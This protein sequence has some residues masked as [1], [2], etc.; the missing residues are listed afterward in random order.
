MDYVLP[1]TILTIVVVANKCGC[2]P[3]P[4]PFEFPIQNS[5]SLNI[6]FED[7]EIDLEGMCE[8]K[9]KIICDFQNI[10]KQLECGIQPDLEFLLEEI[11]AVYEG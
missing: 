7:D 1:K 4:E 6:P 2:N 3:T 9:Q 11:S 5:T 8:L 10:L